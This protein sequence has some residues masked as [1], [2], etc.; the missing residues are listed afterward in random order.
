LSDNEY[1]FGDILAEA[2]KGGGGGKSSTTERLEGT[3]RFIAKYASAANDE[4]ELRKTKKGFPQISIVWQVVG[5]PDNEKETWHNIVFS[6]K[7]KGMAG[8]MLLDLGFTSE[9]LK[10]LSGKD[11]FKA[12][13]IDTADRIQGIEVKMKISPQSNN[14]DFDTFEVLEVINGPHI[15]T[16]T[17][18]SGAA[19]LV[20]SIQPTPNYL[21]AQ[22]PV[23]GLPNSVGA[24]V[25]VGGGFIP[26][27]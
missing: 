16:T 12:A 19:P 21:Q 2:E 17:A 13:L 1:D 9:H 24:P 6:P 3:F 5:G 7:S 27:V 11:R 23:P 14:R 8:K 10:S 22:V 20:S 25:P 4:G 18:P 15:D 26:K